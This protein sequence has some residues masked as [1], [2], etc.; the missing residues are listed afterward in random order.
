MKDLLK[1]LAKAILATIRLTAAASPE[2][3]IYK[4]L[5]G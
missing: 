4:K 3:K 5:S 2:T 1:L